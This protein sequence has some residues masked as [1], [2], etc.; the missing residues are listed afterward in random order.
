M[1]FPKSE[2]NVSDTDFIER[3]LKK[4][5]YTKYGDLHSKGFILIELH[6]KDRKVTSIE[7]W[8]DKVSTT[9]QV[10]NDNFSTGLI[11]AERYFSKI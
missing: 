8:H 10:I 1:Y 7:V 5:G 6:K 11:I 3:Y 4:N 9:K 2:I